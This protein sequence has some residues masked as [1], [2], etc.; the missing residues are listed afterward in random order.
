MRIRVNNNIYSLDKNFQFSG[1]EVQ[2]RLPE[3]FI[4]EGDTVYI[5]TILNSPRAI[6]EMLLTVDAI[7]NLYIGVDIELVSHYLPYARQDR[8]CVNG[9]AFSLRVMCN[10]INSVNFTKVTISDVHSEVATDLLER[11]NNIPQHIIFNSVVR[12]FCIDMSDY[13]LISP[14]KGA[15]PKIKKLGILLGIET[16]HA[17]KIRNPDTGEIVSTNIDVDDFEGKNLFIVDDIADN[18]G[19]FFHLAK[20]LKSKNCGKISLYITHAIFPNGA[21]HLYEYI[22]N[23]YTTN[24]IYNGDDKRIKVYDIMLAQN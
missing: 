4:Q 7:R 1:G 18:G 10:I 17:Y 16:L 3:M 21:T 23:I 12:K 20:L 15:L 2:I 22:D 19:T 5:N 6:M 14:D 13:L 11:V 24:S 8:A 9:E